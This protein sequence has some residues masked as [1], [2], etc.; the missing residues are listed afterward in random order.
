MLNNTVI[1]LPKYLNKLEL[2]EECIKY[3]QS[4]LSSFA[5]IIDNKLALLP[6]DFNNILKKHNTL[7][8]R[9]FSFHITSLPLT[10]EYFDSL[11]DNYPIIVELT[12]EN[13]DTAL[14]NNKVVIPII[15]TKDLFLKAYSKFNVA[16]SALYSGRFLLEE[17]NSFIDQKLWFNGI[18][19]FQD[20]MLKESKELVTYLLSKQESTVIE[21][22]LGYDIEDYIQVEENKE[23]SLI[24]QPHPKLKTTHVKDIY[25]HDEDWIPEKLIDFPAWID[26]LIARVPK[27]Y[28]NTA[29]IEIQDDSIFINYQEPETEEQSI[30]RIS[31]EKAQLI[32]AKMFYQH[33]Q[34]N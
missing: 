11:T 1:M 10:K 12:K 5:Q 23:V 13:I 4:C 17:S 8:E 16:M 34:D 7:S 24:A 18:I 2:T 29:E 26:K 31:E 21:I 19:E 9:M 28:L 6:L 27:E 25:E 20:D 32:K 33:L 15:G 3:N 30:A 22:Q 14:S